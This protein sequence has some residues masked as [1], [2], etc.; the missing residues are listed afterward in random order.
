MPK[1]FLFFAILIIVSLVSPN[2]SL[3][4]E[5]TSSHNCRLWAG[6]SNKTIP[7]QVVEDDLSNQPNSLKNLSATNPD[8]WGIV[9][10]GVFG[11]EPIIDRGN[12]PAKDDQLY[13]AAVNRLKEAK[14]KIIIAH[15]RSAGSGCLG[16]EVRD[17]HP[18]SRK[19]NNQ[20]WT[21]AHNGTIEKEDLIK[22]IGDKY[23]KDNSPN[24]SGL[25]ECSPCRKDQWV[26][27]EL[28]F[29]Y[30]MENIEKN[31]WQ[32]DQALIKSLKVLESARPDDKKNFVL[33]DG[34]NLW[35]YK[36]GYSLFYVNDQVYKYFAVASQYPAATHGNWH[37]LSDGQM[38][39]YSQDQKLKITTVMPSLS[40]NKKTA[41]RI[42]A[43][44]YGNKPTEMIT[45]EDSL[46]DFKKSIINFFFFLL[47]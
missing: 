28:Y 7:G 45:V 16:D 34:H 26:D 39:E 31:D 1:K 22:L 33:S 6:L 24:C 14:S 25:A 20:S 19:I 41:G 9:S 2:F 37:S 35:A 23:L 13:N 44:N 46:K 30:L 17:L 36:S 4:K 29:L 11:A 43:Q 3:A 40:K 12:L 21:F 38:I 15:V 10:Y 27:S 32:V 5:V 18:F 42:N 8:G 47:L